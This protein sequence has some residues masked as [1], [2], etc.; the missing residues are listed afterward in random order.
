MR[1]SEPPR[2]AFISNPSYQLVKKPGC[3][4][5][6]K[7]DVKQWGVQGL[8]DGAFRGEIMFKSSALAVGAVLSLAIAGE[9]VAGCCPTCGCAPVVVPNVPPPPPEPIFVVNQGPVYSGPGPYLNGYGPF[10]GAVPG[11]GYPAGRFSA[12]PQDPFWRVSYPRVYYTYSTGSPYAGPPPL[13]AAP[14]PQYR[15]ARVYPRF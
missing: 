6:T 9:A 15:A 1:T 14:G 2:Q 5:R 13:A 10:V 4:K 7:R 11:P 8:N 12:Y 3:A